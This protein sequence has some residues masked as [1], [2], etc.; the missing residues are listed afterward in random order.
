MSFEQHMRHVESA[1]ELVRVR[2]EKLRQ[3]I[4]TAIDANIAQLESRRQVLLEQVENRH[5]D[6]KTIWAQKEH[7]VMVTAGLESALSFSERVL[8]CT[9]NPELL[10]LAPQACSRLEQLNSL[11]WEPGELNRI[12]KNSVPFIYLQRTLS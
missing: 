7:V 5:D 3:A 9:N 10:S 2:P 12:K 11:T 8:Q 1:E 4:N 6:M